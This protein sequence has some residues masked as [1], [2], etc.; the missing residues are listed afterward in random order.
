MVK[1]LLLHKSKK[2]TKHEIKT[3]FNENMS[4]IALLISCIYGLKFHANNFY[5]QT[6]FLIKCF[7][8]SIF[9]DIVLR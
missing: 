6:S 5:I 2:I 4:E 7:S 8:V 9:I 1:S 3:F